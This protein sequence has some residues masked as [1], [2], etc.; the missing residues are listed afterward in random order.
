[1][2][3]RS[4]FIAHN[5]RE[6]IAQFKAVIENNHLYQ[7]TDYVYDG[8]MFANIPSFD[9]Y[10]VVIVK[11][12]LTHVSGLYMLESTLKRSKKKPGLMLLLTP[13][14]S[15][16]ITS[17]CGEY[18]IIY[19]NV[20]VTNAYNLLDLIYKYDECKLKAG[21]DIQFEIIHLLKRIGILRKYIGYTYFEYI[22]NLACQNAK[23]IDLPMK[24]IYRM[25]GEHF[26]S[27]PLNIEKAMRTCLKASFATNCNAYARSLFG[28]TLEDESY[29]SN[30]N[31]IKVCIKVLK[32]RNRSVSV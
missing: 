31:F 29:P 12:A 30:G 21:S 10:D 23:I 8:M 15:S 24:D 11:D 1:M 16:F 25:I 2:K 4:I 28:I 26:N 3:K 18:G 32:E 17:K 7:L 14:T 6:L 5:N 27:S 22:L 19:K 20:E 9:A 13:F